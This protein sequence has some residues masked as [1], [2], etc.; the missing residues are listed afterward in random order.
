MGE[1]STTAPNLTKLKVINLLPPQLQQQPE[2]GFNSHSRSAGKS[3]SL[4]GSACAGFRAHTKRRPGTDGV[5]GQE[6]GWGHLPF[7]NIFILGFPALPKQP[8]PHPGVLCPFPRASPSWGALPPPPSIPIPAHLRPSCRPIVPL[9]RPI[10]R[11]TGQG[12]CGEPT[13][14]SAPTMGP[15]GRRW[16]P[17]WPIPAAVG[18]GLPR[19]LPAG[20]RD[21]GAAAP[22]RAQGARRGGRGHSTD[23]RIIH[24]H[25]LSPFHCI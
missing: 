4:G 10:P 17:G 13:P 8:N 19:H 23:G 9:P 21:A 24:G 12:G 1:V 14:G 15:G 20:V 5:W 6:Q 2:K 16:S 18:P 22:H 7:L 3:V 25:S 11:Y